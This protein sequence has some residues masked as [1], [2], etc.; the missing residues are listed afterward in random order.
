MKRRILVITDFALY[1][2]DPDADI[3]KRRIALAAVDKLCISNLSDNFF[4]IIVPTEYDCLMASTRKKEIV[5]VIVKAI[6]STS[7]F[8]PEVAFSNRYIVSDEPLI[9]PSS[10]NIIWSEQLLLRPH[11]HPVSWENFRPFKF[12]MY[13]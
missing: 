13:H 11:N 9:C 4:A 12:C 1:L 2:V 3:L 7:E 10:S 8:E 6:K 5:N